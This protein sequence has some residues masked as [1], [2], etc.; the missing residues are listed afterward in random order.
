MTFAKLQRDDME[1]IAYKI[2]NI[3]YFCNKNDYKVE[4]KDVCAEAFG[5]NK[6]YWSTIISGLIE[7]GYIQGAMCS[8][9]HCEIRELRITYKGVEYLHYSEPMADASDYMAW[10]KETYTIHY[11]NNNRTEK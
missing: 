2:L 6:P 9:Y 1:I 3:V 4:E 7:N 8:N 5:I 10:S 11:D